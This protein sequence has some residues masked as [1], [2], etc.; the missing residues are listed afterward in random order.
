MESSAL[1]SVLI[2]AKF[3]D[4]L[5]KRVLDRFESLDDLLCASS[6]Q[7]EDVLATDDASLK[8]A[9][10]A[11]FRA[12]LREQLEARGEAAAAAH[13]DAVTSSG[14][15]GAVEAARSAD[16]AAQ[17][18]PAPL[19][20][21][22]APVDLSHAASSIVGSS[23]LLPTISLADLYNANA[24]AAMYNNNA[25]NANAAA[26]SSTNTAATSMPMAPLATTATTMPLVTPGM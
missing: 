21:L 26:N 10:A 25:N 16:L 1:S 12:W 24:V 22:V 14:A 9:E 2:E 19:P 18:L 3:S 11:R 15:G 17:P 4:T 20:A 6:E 23:G 13:S 5:T 7:F 8:P